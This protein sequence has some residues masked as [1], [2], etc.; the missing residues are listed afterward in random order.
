MRTSEPSNTTSTT[1]MSHVQ[2]AANPSAPTKPPL[3]LP[4]E[5]LQ[6]IAQ[7]TDD[8]D[9]PALRATSRVFRD[10]TETR[11]ADAFFTDVYYPA[12]PEGL[13]RLTKIAE[14]PL[15][16]QKVR[17][18]IATTT[19]SRG[20]YSDFK[21][22]KPLEDIA[23][24][25][26]GRNFGVLLV[27]DES[28]RARNS[29]ASRYVTWL[30]SYKPEK[31]TVDVQLS[32]GL[33][34]ATYSIIHHLYEMEAEMYRCHAF[35]IRILHAR[36]SN[37]PVA[38][39][40]IEKIK[41]HRHLKLTYTG[42]HEYFDCAHM[43][44]GFDG[45]FEINIPQCTMRESHGD[46][47]LQQIVKDQRSSLRRLTIRDVHITSTWMHKELVDAITSCRLDF[48]HINNLTS[49]GAGAEFKDTFEASGV[50]EIRAGM[51]EIWWTWSDQWRDRRFWDLGKQRVRRRGAK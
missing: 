9:L 44:F 41:Y 25:M 1:T 6:R 15:F 33:T 23:A 17:N 4:N 2:S 38:Q 37:S 35:V 8:E 46:N 34:P 22:E 49:S 43:F 29:E 51:L 45:L 50:N 11:F 48:C 20:R 31:F 32:T 26:Q 3:H 24:V 40:T 12:T 21:T 14:H 10:E 18:C 47:S 42:L 16:S 7:L 13:D 19:K 36:A 5:I 27:N 28:Q 30:N 39:A